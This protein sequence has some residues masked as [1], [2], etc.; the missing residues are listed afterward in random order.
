MLSI[1]LSSLLLS[2]H[3]PESVEFTTEEI[4]Q[5]HDLSL[6]K[7]LENYVAHEWKA[8]KR[9]VLVENILE[10]SNFALAILSGS[11]L[12]KG[13]KGRFPWSRPCRKSLS[14]LAKLGRA[15]ALGVG[16]AA[17][18]YEAHRISASE[19]SDPEELWIARNF[20]EGM[21]K[22]QHQRLEAIIA[23]HSEVLARLSPQRSANFYP[24][25]PAIFFEGISLKAR[26]NGNSFHL[27]TG[28]DSD[29]KI[30]E[31][32]WVSDFQN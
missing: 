29:G 8:E 21:E 31:L 18:G 23:L 27:E 17:G 3:A 32:K 22:D 20:Y 16:L 2:I 26:I 10:K 15:S 9:K 19:I 7:S 1:L 13:I 4:R 30:S 14:R 5:L 11:F 24:D 28:R 25:F 12:W 6:R